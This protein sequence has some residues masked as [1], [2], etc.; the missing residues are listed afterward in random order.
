MLALAIT[1]GS[2][3]SYFGI[4]FAW[5]HKMLPTWWDK[6]AEKY[7]M[8]AYGRSPYTS[9]SVHK[10]VKEQYFWKALVWPF[11]LP[12]YFI[13]EGLDNAVEKS[14][15]LTIERKMREKERELA[16]AKKREKEL[17]SRLLSED[18]LDRMITEAVKKHKEETAA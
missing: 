10:S 12:V 6:A 9:L 8:Y 15:P 3:A 7:D 2:I 14:N 18:D 13:S 4:G 17:E 11:A 16:E 5:S 1:L